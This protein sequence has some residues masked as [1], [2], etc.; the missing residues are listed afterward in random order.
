MANFDFFVGLETAI[1]FSS[2]S[3]VLMTDVTLFL[4]FE[5]ILI[6]P[7]FASISL[8]SLSSFLTTVSGMF[9]SRAWRMFVTILRFFDSGVKKSFIFLFLI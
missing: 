3:S 1:D 7:F 9:P 4:T 8:I 6:D 5:F 2:I